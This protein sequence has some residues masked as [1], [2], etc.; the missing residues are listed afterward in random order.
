MSCP[1]CAKEPDRRSVLLRFVRWAAA[2]SGL[3]LI[4]PL[5]RFS[6]FTIKPKPKYIKIAAPL[7][8]SGVHA[9]REF[10]LFASADRSTAWAVSRTCTHLGC[11]VNFL[12]DKQLIECPCHQSRFTPQGERLAGP[13]QRNLPV[14]PVEV[15]QDATGKVTGYVVT[16]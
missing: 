4:H 13:A 8:R 12:E 6:G 15:E 10:F 5:F 16:V 11:R 14:F 3:A 9:E 2:L 1:D 7:P